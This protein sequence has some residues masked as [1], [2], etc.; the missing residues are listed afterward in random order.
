MH[1]KVKSLRSELLWLGG[2][3]NHFIFEFSDDGAPESRD[4]TMTIGTLTSWNFGSRTRSR[5]YQYTLHGV[6]CCE[7]DPVMEQIWEQHSEEML[8]LEGNTLTIDGE[9]ITIEFTPSA[10]QAWQFWAA[11]CLTQ[12]ATYPSNYANVHKAD[13]GE[14]FYFLFH[15]TN[16]SKNFNS[17][18][19]RY[20]KI[21]IKFH[22][23]I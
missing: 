4:K 7:K 22:C 15:L 23:S 5:E 19:T 10:D 20:E 18:Q 6:T 12:S 13:L 8:V 21:L 17:N 3:T 1:L 16:E 9:I 2:R 11:N 14:P